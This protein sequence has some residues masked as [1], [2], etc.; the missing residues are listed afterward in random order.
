ML[1]SKG[2][3]ELIL[4]V[5]VFLFI[6]SSNKLNLGTFQLLL[7][8]RWICRG[9]FIQMSNDENCFVLGFDVGS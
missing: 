7:N 3:L 9:C 2:W 6:L 8:Q 1:L 4:G 5:L